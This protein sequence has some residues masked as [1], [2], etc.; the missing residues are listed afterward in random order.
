MIRLA[1]DNL[2]VAIVYNADSHCCLWCCG[3]CHCCVGLIII[4]VLHLHHRHHAPSVEARSNDSIQIAHL[5]L[6]IEILIELM[7]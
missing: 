1:V 3:D 7:S 2:A 5:T 6:E 4:V